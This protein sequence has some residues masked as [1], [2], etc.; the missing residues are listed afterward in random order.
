MPEWVVVFPSPQF[1]AYA[2]VCPS[3]SMVMVSLL[4]VV[5]H[6]VT[7]SLAPKLAAFADAAAA[8]PNCTLSGTMSSG[9]SQTASIRLPRI[10]CTAPAGMVKFNDAVP[11]ILMRS[12]STRVAVT[13][14]LEAT[15]PCSGSVLLP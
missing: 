11:N 8:K 2:P 5:R 12:S 13:V 10:S 14:S 4:P 3:T 6:V 9:M 1:T 7:K 15:A